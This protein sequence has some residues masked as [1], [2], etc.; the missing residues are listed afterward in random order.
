MVN[1]ELK[2]VSKYFGKIT[3]AENVSFH[4]NEG[5][6]FFLLGPS[7]C[8]KTTILR[9]LAG[10]YRPD[11]GDIL[12]NGKSVLDIPAHKR[13]VG[14]VFQN[15]ALWPHMTVYDNIAYGL[16]IRGLP[17]QER[18]ARVKECLKIVRMEDYAM[19][20]PNQLS[21]GQQQRVALA[22]A[23]AIQ[24]NL[25]LL[26]EPLSNLDAKLRL[27]TRGE[28]KKIQRE[29]KITTI[30]VTHDQEEALS[31]ADR[32]AI[33]NEGKIEQIGS[34]RDVYS[35]PANRFVAEFIGETNIIEGSINKIIKNEGLLVVDTDYGLKI[36]GKLPENKYAEG[37]RVVC[38]VRPE[39]LEI[40]DAPQGG[41]DSNV[42]KAK[43]RVVSYYGSSE[44]YNLE[45]PRDLLLKA[46]EFGFY[47]RRREGDIVYVSF[48]PEHVKVFPR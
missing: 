3:A 29:L 17:I 1:I 38:L 18:V 23:L 14:M 31:M 11:R 12:F 32:V 26:D 7:G 45:G 30:Y 44:H 27:E 19:R 35:D 37:Q 2:H 6:L 5:E 46:V 10:F 16:K 13:N 43:I 22:R 36:Y 41:V 15:Y 25:L 47:H 21:G 28:I 39:Y 9:I 24:P 20:Y 34:P 8:G 42:F 33:M 48:R 4:V 40:F